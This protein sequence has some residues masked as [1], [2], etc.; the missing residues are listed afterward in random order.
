MLALWDLMMISTFLCHAT[1]MVRQWL[2]NFFT[3]L[4]GDGY[5]PRKLTILPRHAT[6]W[7]GIAKKSS[8]LLPAQENIHVGRMPSRRRLKITSCIQITKFFQ[9]RVILVYLSPAN[10]Q[11]LAAI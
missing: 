2:R 9:N 10:G 4:Q 7:H 3:A 1:S 5:G 6:M 11:L 8:V